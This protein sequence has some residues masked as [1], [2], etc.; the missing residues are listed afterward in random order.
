MGSSAAEFLLKH[1]QQAISSSFGTMGRCWA[2][3]E[4]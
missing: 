3:S 1:G 2:L 4:K